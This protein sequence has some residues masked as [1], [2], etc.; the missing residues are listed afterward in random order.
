VSLD[1]WVPPVIDSF[2]SRV[3]H[4]SPSL[5]HCSVGPVCRRQSPHACA[6][7]LSLPR[8]P[9][10][11]D[12]SS[13]TSRL[14]TS[15]MDASTSRISRPPPHALDRFRARTP[16]A[17]C[18]L[19]ICAPSRALSLS[20]SLSLDLRAHPVSSAAAHRSPPPILRSSLSPRRTPC[21]GEFRLTVSDSGYPSICP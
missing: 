14:C 15:V 17:H 4:L 9:H 18:P 11:S 21:L 13:L 20:L 10:P 6:R 2:L 19:L 3:R 12:P 7:P 5:F 16:L 8:G 1:R